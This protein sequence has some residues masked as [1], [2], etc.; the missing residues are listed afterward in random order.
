MPEH[1]LYRPLKLWS[2]NQGFGQNK[3][4]VSLDGQHYINCDGKKP[5]AG[6]RSVYSN[7]DGHNGLDLRAE[8]WT[9]VYAAHSGFI[10]EIQTEEERGL[11]VGI[12]S[13][14]P[15]FIVETGKPEYIKTRY[16]HLCAI[17]VD[18]GEEVRVGT[19]IGYADSTGAS[20]GDHLH[21]ELKP[22]A[23]NARG[24]WYNVLQS[25]GYFGAIDPTTY[26]APM[27]A[28]DSSLLMRVLEE[29]AKR[30]NGMADKLRGK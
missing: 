30:L 10:E 29:I 13:N 12:V 9:P 6:Y 23:K 28:V 3:V 11:G 21:F 15:H 20:T 16:W 7:M 1:F 4:C 18:K 19:L 5:P 24:I 22:V 17:D 27:F 8:R 14:V 2:I 25:N 26:I